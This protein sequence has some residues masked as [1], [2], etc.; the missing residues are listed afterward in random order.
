MKKI[1]SIIFIAVA[2]GSCSQC[3]E[4]TQEIQVNGQITTTEPREV[5]SA[6]GTEID[7]LEA[8]GYTCTGV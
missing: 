4:C 2:L 3:Y 1:V 7:N 5:C 6:D 8:D